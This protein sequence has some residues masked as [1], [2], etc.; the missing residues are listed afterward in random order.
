MNILQKVS[1]LWKLN[2]EV[3][4]MKLSE[5]NTSEG[6]LAL[7]MNI[8]TIYS[9][10]QGFLPPELVAKIGVVSLAIYTG[11][12]ALVKAAQELVKLTKTDKDDK[13]V[14]EIDKALE[15]AAGKS[16]APKP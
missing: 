14:A 11:G 9:A 12:R 7:L 5:L 1:A 10:V 15:A 13:V 3:S 6:R 8:V 2:K 16:Q 4:K